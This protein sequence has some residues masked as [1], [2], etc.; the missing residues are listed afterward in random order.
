MGKTKPKAPLKPTAAYKPQGE[1]ELNGMLLDSISRTRALE[2]HSTADG[3]HH[4]YLFR[5][6][7]GIISD[8]AHSRES[9]AALGH[10]AEMAANSA[11]LAALR[12]ED[13]GPVGT[14]ARA[15]VQALHTFNLS[16]NKPKESAHAPAEESPLSALKEAVADLEAL[17][18]PREAEPL[19]T[20]FHGEVG[21]PD[22]DG[23]AGALAAG[24]A[25]G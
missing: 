17:G 1:N 19:D 11:I 4:A 21:R 23:G 22:P 7:S 5:F 25:E 24:E 12:I 2:H 16:V 10:V 14:A 13:P 20:Y 3:K 9:Q 15:F 8:V 18:P 6:A